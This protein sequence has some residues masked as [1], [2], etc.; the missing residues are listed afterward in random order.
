MT[1]I[2]AN[3]VIMHMQRIVGNGVLS[4]TAHES[5][6]PSHW[7]YK[8]QEIFKHDSG[9]ASNGIMPIPYFMNVS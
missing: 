7:Y 9:L 8:L 4:V 5:E 3:D 2:K 6:H 1:F